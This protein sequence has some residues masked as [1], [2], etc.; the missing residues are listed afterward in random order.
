MHLIK[1]GDSGDDRVAFVQQGSRSSISAGIFCF[2]LVH[3]AI[4]V[5]VGDV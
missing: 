2:L 3:N 5:I 4:A 1:L